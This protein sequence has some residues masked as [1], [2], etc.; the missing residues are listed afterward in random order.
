MYGF[1]TQNQTCNKIEGNKTETC[2]DLKYKLYV[3]KP[4]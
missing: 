3:I 1:E 4:P 2:N